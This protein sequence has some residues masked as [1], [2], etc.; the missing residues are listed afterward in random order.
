[1]KAQKSFSDLKIKKGR[2]RPRSASAARDGS[3]PLDFSKLLKREPDID[4]PLSIAEEKKLNRVIHHRIDSVK[5]SWS[6]ADRRS[7]DLATKSPS[8][9]FEEWELLSMPSLS[10]TVYVDTPTHLDKNAEKGK[11]YAWIGSKCT[12]SLVAFSNAIGV[13]RS[14]IRRNQKTGVI[15]YLIS[16]A[17]REKA[18]ANGAVSVSRAMFRDRV[19]SESNFRKE[20]A[21][22]SKPKVENV[23]SGGELCPYCMNPFREHT[24]HDTV[25]DAM[26]LCDFRVVSTEV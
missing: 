16:K 6:S 23:L 25:L 24:Q 13:S 3:F 20:N 5:N 7:R 21:K 4:G 19:E 17:V 10:E 8:A 11:R 22:S 15:Y 2:G 26:I 14:M 1:M 12:S 18:I 9:N